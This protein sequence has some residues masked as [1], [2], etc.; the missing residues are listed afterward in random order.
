MLSKNSLLL[1]ILLLAMP[2]FAEITSTDENP[3][4][5]KTPEIH[6][7]KDVVVTASR[8][9]EDVH[10][11]QTNITAEDLDF[12]EPDL[13][14]PMLLQD[15]PGVFAYSDAGSN[16]G[17]TYVKI[18]GFDQRR[19]GVLI[20]GIPFNDP[21]DHQLWWVDMPDLASSVQDIQVQR[22]V[23]NSI[24][25][26]S[27]MGG[28]INIVTGRLSSTEQGRVSISAG[29]DG[30]GRQMLLYE[31]GDLKGGLRSSFRLS[32]QNSDG[33]RDRTGVEQ[34][35][36]FWSGEH[37]NDVSTTRINIYTGREVTHHA[38]NASPES[39]LEQNRRH[40]PET[41]HNAIDDFTQPHY[42]LHNDLFL[43]DN[44][45]LKNS[46]YYVQ[47]EGFYEN[48]K[49]GEDAQDYALDQH[50]GLAADD[51][52]DLIRRKYVRKDHV[53]W[54]PRAMYEHEKGRF[55]IGGD[56][57]NFHSSHWGEV[58]NV[59]GYQPDDFMDPQ[60]KYHEYTGDKKAYSLY[61]N[62]RY[63]II[64]GLTLMGDL[65]FQHKEYDFLQRE[66]GNFA[67]D[68]RNGY[69]VDYDFFN[70]KGGM[71][72]H[73]GNVAGGKFALFG[74]IGVS[75]REPTD[76]ELFDTWKGGDDLGVQPLF[77]QSRNVMKDDGTTIDHVQWW[78]PK[79]KEEELIDY[80]MG[81]SWAGENLSFTLG[82]Y[83]MDFKNEIVPYGGTDEDGAGIRGNA[84]KTLH[85][86]L[87][88]G[89]RARIDQGNSLILAASRSWD[90]YKNFQFVDWDGSTYDYSGNAIA[91][92]PEHLLSV[93]WQ[94]QWN[95]GVRSLIRVRNV[96]Q[97]HLDNTGDESRIIDP[98]TT[99]DL[100]LWFDLDQVGLTALE[101]AKAFIHLR[102]IGGVE[103]ETN[104]YYDS[105]A[106]E[107]YYITGAGRNFAL[108]I[109][110]DF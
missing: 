4:N 69:T 25:G 58:M 57:Y 7:S 55:V 110:Y 2:A 23:T 10:L 59:S 52:V 22:G 35:G 100:S 39:A 103:Y 85:R 21:E 27:P 95:P 28:T 102:N 40:N 34:W 44:W 53:G 98:W 6:E 1:L 62:E 18:R 86:G 70:P 24:G 26:L 108:G 75:H 97:Q 67:G 104:G 72:W 15:V 80:E 31:T 91:L 79:V 11:N 81:V 71:H 30:F 38:W 56:T 88:L 109:D 78:D 83:Y 51:E 47:G 12:R 29:S 33:Y 68:Q 50:L 46:V 74:S 64:D 5:T 93:S 41:Y 48:F 20:N 90:E 99:L 107:K 54:V 17:Y 84:D 101:S 60:F 61:A 13:P 42:E 106:G 89:L 82:G 14:M 32:R 9:D 87:E 92:F 73:A 96:G 8:Y 76:G 49:D 19:V 16:L 36:V 77:N 45:T 63:E 37:S 66:V 3:A 43:S 65:Q 105:W 94:T